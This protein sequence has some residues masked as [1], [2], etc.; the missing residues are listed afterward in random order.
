MV[1][2]NT[3]EHCLPLI[4]NVLGNLPTILIPPGEEAKSLET[5]QRI[6]S[7]LFALGADRHALLLNLGGG[8]IGDMGGFAASCY[9]RGIDFIQIPTTLLSQVDASVGG[10]LGI[11]YDGLKNSIGL[12]R[13]PNAVII[14]TSFLKTLSASELR[15]GYAEVV[16]HALIADAE[17]WSDLNR[18]NDPGQLDWS[19]LVPHSICIKH[20]I[21]TRD[22]FEKSDRKL[23]NFGHT[24]G[25]AVES[26]L[27]SSRNAIRHG[28]AV[29]LGMICETHLSVARGLASEL[30]LSEIS[31]YLLQ[32][33]G[34]V[35][36]D[37]ID[38]TMLLARMKHD[39]KNTGSQI[40]FTLLEAIGQG[41]INHQPSENQIAQSLNY[42]RGL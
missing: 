26:V 31:Q 34:K 35:D 25:H 24:I 36:L 3:N 19:R 6:W 15:S 13:N 30:A 20:D 14:E 4:Q 1:D 12:F 40:N 11:D 37:S 23:L 7:A 10:K 2:D 39:K 27:L 16:K 28:E 32:V 9:M 38:N 29:A 17:L 42:Y 8:V 41:S 21:V 22:P 18:S 33:Y 5:C